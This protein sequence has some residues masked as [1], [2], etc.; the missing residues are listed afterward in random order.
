MR[1]LLEEEEDVAH[2]VGRGV[3]KT[4]CCVRFIIGCNTTTMQMCRRL[5]W[6]V[7]DLLDVG[8]GSSKSTAEN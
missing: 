3:A 7:L 6:T 8:R 5:I 2:N 4:S 1:R